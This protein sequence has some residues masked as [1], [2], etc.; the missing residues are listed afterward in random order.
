MSNIGAEVAKEASKKGYADVALDILSKAKGFTLTAIGNIANAVNELVGTADIYTAVVGEHPH[1]GYKVGW[2]ERITLAAI[3]LVPTKYVAKGVNVAGNALEYVYSG[4]ASVFKAKHPKVSQQVIESATD[5]AKSVTDFAMQ[6]ANCSIGCKPKNVKKNVDDTF[7]SARN[8]GFTKDK[9]VAQLAK[10]WK[11]VTPEMERKI[12][13]GSTQATK[14]R[15]LIGVHSP[16]VLNDDK[17][18]ITDV[19]ANTD[20]TK[21]VRLTKN[22]GNGV[23]S[24]RKKTTLFPESWSDAKII[25]ASRFTSAYP[26][27]ARRARDGATLHMGKVDGVEIN[28]IK[29]GDDV[30]SAFP[31]GGTGQLLGGFERL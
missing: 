28:V 2:G 15:D 17:F 18:N 11:S 1:Y 4:V 5:T 30:T 16:K 22:L 7:D 23:W 29:N 9:D 10:G 25:N 31:T 14:P 24:K 12:L 19:I 6:K 26:P 8:T 21:S 27:I 20:G 13:Y 3:A